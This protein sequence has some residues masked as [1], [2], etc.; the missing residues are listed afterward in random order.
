[1]RSLGGDWLRN[2][3]AICVDNHGDFG[4]KVCLSR[5]K[6]WFASYAISYGSIEVLLVSVSFMTVARFLRS[7]TLGGVSGTCKSLGVPLL[8]GIFGL[9]NTFGAQF[10]KC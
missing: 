2:P 8:L 6:Y 9:E 4:I 3:T 1:M 10:R 5:M 7:F